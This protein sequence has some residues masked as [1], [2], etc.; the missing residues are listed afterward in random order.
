[1]RTLVLCGD[2]WHPARVAQA[3][4]APLASAGFEFDWITHAGEWSAALMAE[5]PLVV[6]TR[7]NQVSETDRAP[8]ATEEVQ[9]A[10][11]DHVRGG[12]GLLV[13]HSG[14]AGYDALPAMRGL[15]GGAFVSH[16]PQCPVTVEAHAGHPLATGSAPFTLTDEHYVMDLD[17]AQA[18][19]FLTT[20]SE[21][22]TQHGG[23]TRR[24]GDGRVCVLTPGHNLE[25]WL[26]PSY[27]A[28]I[29]NALRWCGGTE[30]RVS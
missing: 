28:L 7:M 25:V 10:F 22:G 16:P 18:D 11:V 1:M 8:W 19:V 2:Y 15:V 5:Y 14:A 27:Q 23:W 30:V 13:I 21:H 12:S 26:H 4:L 17:D 9:A 6:L 29:G 20:T 24:E 3:G